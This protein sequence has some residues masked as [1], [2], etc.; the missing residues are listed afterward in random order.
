METSLRLPRIANSTA[1]QVSASAPTLHGGAAEERDSHRV[2]LPQIKLPSATPQVVFEALV[3]TPIHVPSLKSPV[4]GHDPHLHHG[5]FIQ[6]S[7]R[8]RGIARGSVT[9]LTTA[10]SHVSLMRGGL[11]PTRILGIVEQVHSFQDLSSKTKQALPGITNYVCYAAGTVLHREGD[12]PG[13]CYVIVSGEVGIYHKL[14]E[15]KVYDDDE[16][17]MSQAPSMNRAPTKHS[18]AS[19]GSEGS[20]HGDIVSALQPIPTVEGYSTYT[21][22]TDLGV[23]IEKCH[24]RALVGDL[25]LLHGSPRQHSAKLLQD[26]ELLEI[27]KD[28]FDAVLRDELLAVGGS[29][30]DFLMEHVPGMRKANQRLHRSFA[31]HGLGHLFR[32]K[33]FPKGH[34]FIQQG[35]VAEDAIYV[36]SSGS[37]AR[38][39]RGADL[40]PPKQQARKAPNSSLQ[41]E[42]EPGTRLGLLV[43]GGVFGALPLQK[44]HSPR[45][46][47][48]FSFIAAE[49]C[50]AYCVMGDVVQK[51]PPQL[52]HAIREYLSA[53]TAWRLGQLEPMIMAKPKSK[54]LG[55][56]KHAPASSGV[57]KKKKPTRSG[58]AKRAPPID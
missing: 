48:P 31:A 54:R 29:K 39:C 34:V 27:P 47:E 8:N 22:K 13:C 10:T 40:L 23:L 3:P 24:A 15:D 57:S 52:L 26:C 11:N 38:H 50:E 51:L 49:P 6:Q 19:R 1:L 42:Q 2:R 20:F 5:D 17:P 28:A 36:V 7:R 56:S 55:Q 12:F 21:E 58:Q 9:H 46:Q 32:R 43:R 30:E 4:T 53:S 41:K 33:N 44:S 25:A 37:V 35:H 18:V 16:A 14:H 45:F